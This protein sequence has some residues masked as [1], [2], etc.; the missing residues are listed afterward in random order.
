MGGGQGKGGAPQAPDFSK[1]AMVNQT[2]P[3]GS[4]SWS[5]GGRGG[6]GG[7]APM[8]V[9]QVLNHPGGLWQGM[10]EYGGLGNNAPLSM[11]TS[12]SGPMQGVFNNITQGMA[13]GSSFDPAQAGQQ[14][15]DR[16]YGAYQSRLDPMW[17]QREKSFNAQMANS[18]IDA[19][20]EGYTGAARSFNEG[21][22]DAYNQAIGQ[23][24]GLGQAEQAQARQN[25]MLPFSQA[26]VMMGM[27]PHGNPAAPFQGAMAQYSAAKDQA[28]AEN[29][30]K[31]SALGGVGNIAGTLFGGPLGGMVGGAAGQGLG[32]LLGGGGYSASDLG[33]GYDPNMGGYSF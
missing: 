14:A 4:V 18:G 24:V 19:G 10:A 17:Q 26:G 16:V 29:S 23:S 25:A 1:L 30:K 5:G 31:G 28:S 6:G 2:N 22:N 27:L 15:F 12:F 13:Q 8:D 11:D 21:R 33:N 7:R 32:S 9:N 20:T 3:F